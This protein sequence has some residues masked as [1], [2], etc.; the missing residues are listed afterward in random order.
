MT[1]A[2]YDAL[3]ARGHGLCT[4]PT[5]RALTWFTHDAHGK[6]FCISCGHEPE[7]ARKEAVWPA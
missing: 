6:L 7:T 4:C 2:E 1:Q 5:C 3:R